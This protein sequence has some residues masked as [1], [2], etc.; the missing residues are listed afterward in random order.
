MPARMKIGIQSQDWNPSY[1]T[2]P[3]NRDHCL[4]KLEELVRTREEL[5]ARL[6][7]ILKS[8]VHDRI[9]DAESEFR[10]HF[11]SS[12]CSSPVVAAAQDGSLF[13]EGSCLEA[14][15]GDR[16]VRFLLPF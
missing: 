5:M 11:A 3:T 6:L 2:M 7:V 13:Q 1:I 10:A 8:R 12:G 14:R 4:E 9:E 16:T 15:Q